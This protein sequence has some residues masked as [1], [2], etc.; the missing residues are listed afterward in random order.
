MSG[1]KRIRKLPTLKFLSECFSYNPKTGVLRWKV[2]PKAHFTEENF[3]ERGWKRFNSTWAGEIAGYVS[4]NVRYRVVGIGEHRNYLVHRI[5]M[6]LMTGKEPLA[7]IDHIDGDKF[8]NRWANLRDATMPE[9]G[10][11]RVV[12]RNN[13]SGYR[14]VSWVS[15]GRKHWRAEIMRNGVSR[16]LGAFTTPEAAAAAYE[17]A[18]R[19]IH[20]RFYLANGRRK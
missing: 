7:T 1:I 4:A 19:K 8:N 11:N 2:R 12:S 5:I 16:Y 18:A 3:P 10:G 20:G 17:I 13:T 9:Q 15:T 14:G 6:K